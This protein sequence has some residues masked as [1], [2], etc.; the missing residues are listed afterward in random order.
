MET[1]YITILVT[2]PDNTTAERIA[3]QLLEKKLAACINIVPNLTS[4][5]KWMGK[6]ETSQETLMIIKTK[7]E[8]FEEIKKEIRR[9]H[10]YQVPEIISIPIQDGNKEYLKWIEEE[11]TNE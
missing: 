7:T 3:Y 9:I 4:I 10:P 5:Y 2:T 11:T 6:I 1:K 8:L